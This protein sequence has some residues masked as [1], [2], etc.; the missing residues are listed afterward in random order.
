LINGLM[1]ND[2]EIDSALIRLRDKSLKT[3]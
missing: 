3:H 1:S 2:F